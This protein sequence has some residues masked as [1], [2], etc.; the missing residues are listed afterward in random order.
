MVSIDRSREQPLLAHRQARDLPRQLEREGL[1]AEKEQ[2]VRFLHLHLSPSTHTLPLSVSFFC[3]LRAVS[4]STHLQVLF[5][6]LTFH[7]LAFVQAAENQSL[8]R[9]KEPWRSSH[10]LLR[11]PRGASRP[12]VRRGEG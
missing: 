8:D 4:T 7:T 11:R 6:S 3:H 9:R 1:R 10:S 2:V 5:A 12:Y